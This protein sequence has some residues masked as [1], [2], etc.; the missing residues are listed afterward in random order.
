MQFFVW[1]LINLGIG[2][3]GF[4][5]AMVRTSAMSLAD[6]QFFSKIL[7]INGWIDFAYIAIGWAM[8]K[9]GALKW[10]GHGAGIW[11]QGVFLLL[12][13]WLNYGVTILII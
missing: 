3:Y 9:Y 10:Q 2:M 13:D 1:G 12:F 6:Y 5:N 7:M 8:L 4:Y 11:H